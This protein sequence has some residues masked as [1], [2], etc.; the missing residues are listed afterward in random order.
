MDIKKPSSETK[1]IASILEEANNKY[2]CIDLDAPYQRGFVWKEKKQKY[3][4]NSIMCNLAPSIITINLDTKTGKKT[5]IDGKQRLTSIKRFCENKFFVKLEN[6]NNYCFNKKIDDVECKLFSD[7]QKSHFFNCSLFVVTY[8]DLTY[9]QQIDLFERLQGGVPVQGGEKIS[10]VI[11]SED[12][13]INFNDYCDSQLKYVKKFVK[14]ERN[15]H[16]SLISKLFLFV[17]N[18]TIE[19]IQKSKMDN[20]VKELFNDDCIESKEIK[21]KTAVAIEKIFDVLNSDKIP[22]SLNGNILLMVFHKIYQKYNKNWKKLDVDKNNIILTIK[23]LHKEK[24]GTSNSEKVLIKIGDMYDKYL[25]K[26]MKNVK[27][28]KT[29]ENIKSDSSSDSESDDSSYES[30]SSSEEEIP[31]IKPKKVQKVLKRL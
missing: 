25:D 7:K 30:N 14:S 28:S 12:N 17:K 2:T 16:K 4:I 20:I 29:T 10:C 9:S 21:Q 8:S 31:V 11:T 3:F 13:C 6:D 1:T 19:Q 5:C 15:E 18:D 22:K 24:I 23:E 27:K 26:Y